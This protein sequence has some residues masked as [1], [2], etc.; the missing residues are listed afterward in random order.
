MNYRQLMD[1]TLAHL[2]GTP[3]ILLHSCCAPCSTS[4]IAVLSSFFKITVFYYNPNIDEQEE[5]IKRAKEQ[6]RLI[7]IMR[8]PNPVTFLEGEYRSEDFTTGAEQ[9]ASERE[10]GKRCTFCYALRLDRTAR[11]AS[12]G[13]YDYFT[14]TLSVSPMKDAVRINDIG[15]GL[16]KK[17]GCR[18]LWSDFK[19]KDGFKKSVALSEEYGLYRQDY[20]GCSYSR[21]ERAEENARDN[22]TD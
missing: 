6:E 4:V 9:L 22:K 15:S 21:R 14:T 12:A 1:E 5:Y 3:T 16:E 13:K 10:G 17:Y 8:T 18:W 11:E 2:E 19:K 20:C 7:G